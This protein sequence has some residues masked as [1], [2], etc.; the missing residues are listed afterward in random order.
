MDKLEHYFVRSIRETEAEK[1][2]K[3][4]L[5]FIKMTGSDGKDPVGFG[6]HFILL[7]CDYTKK[8]VR[9]LE[10]SKI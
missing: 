3:G 5:N 2:L 10:W 8:Y 1:Y 9:R 7:Q 4:E 6:P